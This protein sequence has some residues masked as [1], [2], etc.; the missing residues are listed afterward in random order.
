MSFW[1]AADTRTLAQGDWL[2]NCP[3]PV[4]RPDF[5]ALPSGED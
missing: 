2:P 3:I 5:D 4:F 1:I